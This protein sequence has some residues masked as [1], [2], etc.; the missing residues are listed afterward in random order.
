MS[1]KK[2]ISQRHQH[3]SLYLDDMVSK[4]FQVPFPQMDLSFHVPGVFA[5]GPWVEEVESDSL[6]DRRWQTSF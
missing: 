3:L 1:L 2:C 4:N 5:E 6:W